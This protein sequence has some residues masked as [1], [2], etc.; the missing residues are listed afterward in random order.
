VGLVSHGTGTVQ[1]TGT[2]YWYCLLVLHHLS[3]GYQKTRNKSTRT[4]YLVLRLFQTRSARESSLPPSHPQ[5][6]VGAGVLLFLLLAVVVAIESSSGHCTCR[7]RRKCRQM[8]AL[9]RLYRPMET[10]QHLSNDRDGNHRR[11]EEG[12]SAFLKSD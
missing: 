4:Y 6:G 7:H 8:Q 9:Q 10:T 2:A 11:N 5:F 1:S 3:K 12:P